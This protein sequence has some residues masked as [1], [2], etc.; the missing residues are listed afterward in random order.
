M[1]RVEKTARAQQGLY[2][3]HCIDPQSPTYNVSCNFHLTGQIDKPALERSIA[4][5]I[6]RHDAL[7]TAFRLDDEH[8]VQLI[9]TGTQS[10]D[11]VQSDD[12]DAAP[13]F[14]RFELLPTGLD[15]DQLQLLI[16][17]E[18]NKPFDLHQAPLFRSTLFS[19]SDAQ[20]HVLVMTVHHT[21]F[22]HQ[23]KAV[24][25]S[26]LGALYNHYSQRKSL[27]LEQHAVQFADYIHAREDKLQS[28]NTDRSLKFWKKKLNKIES[29]DLP[30]DNQR[31][32]L[33]S[34]DGVRIE[35]ELPAELIESIKDFARS[36]QV[37]FFIATL[38]VCKA[39]LALWTGKQDIP[40]GTHIAD[41]TYPGTEHTIGFLLN[42]LVLRTQIGPNASFTEVLKSVQKTSFNAFRYA[43]TPFETL[44]DELQPV[45]DYQKNAF[46]DVRFSHLQSE[47][48]PLQ[49]DGVEVEAID[50]VQCRARY[51]LTFSVRESGQRCFVQAEYRS[52][53][54]YNDT[55]DWLLDNYIEL[56]GKLIRSPETRLDQCT[57]I[58]NDLHDKLVHRYND[59]Q[60]NYPK[61]KTLVD[62][63]TAQCQQSPN[64]SALHCD[65]VTISYH[66]LLTHSGRLAHY[67]QSQ[68]VRPGSL[69]AISLERS[70]DMVV[71]ALAVL[72]AGATYLPID[73]H[74]PDDRIQHMINDSGCAHIISQ[75]WIEK[76]LPKS[77]ALIISLDAER[78]AINALPELPLA[79]TPAPD[80]LAYI[81]YTSGSTGLPKG[82]QVTHQN[83]V[84]FLCGM[85]AQPGIT[86]DDRLVAVTTLS[87]DIAVLEIWLPLI[88]GATSIIATS[89][90]A[91]DGQ[92]LQHLLHSQQASM[93]QATP[94]TWRL[95]IS[96][97][98][99]GSETFKA[100]CGGE[101]MPVDLAA[102]LYKRCGE[103]WNMYGPTETTVW[104]SVYQI[105]EP[106]QPVL[107]GRP[108][109]NTSM[110]ILD[111]QMRPCYPGV[112]GE[113]FIGGDGV[114]AGY[115]GRDE[116]T[117]EKFVQNPFFDD[118]RI[119]A[120]GDAA[121]YTSDGNIECL[122]RLDNQVK[123]RGHRI[124]L[125]EIESRLN[126]HEAV[127]QSMATTVKLA[128]DDIRIV[129]GVE[130]HANAPEVIDNAQWREWLRQ[131]LPDY[132]VPQVIIT[133]DELPLT[134]NGKLDRIAL[135][136]A[137]LSIG[138]PSENAA[139]AQ[140]RLEKSMAL[141]WSEL[142]GMEQ[143]PVNQTFFD[144]GGHSM[145]AM[146]ML[147][148]VRNEL[149]IDIDPVAMASRS[150]RELLQSHDDEASAI[151]LPANTQARASV[152]T[153][154]FCDNELYARLHRPVDALTARGAVLLCNPI[155]VEAGNILWAYQR[156]ATL[157]S[158][159]GYYVIRFDYY[160]CGNS[161]GEDEDGSA[162]RWKRDVAAAADELLEV[163]GQ[164]SLSLIGFRYGATL[165]ASLDKVRVDKLILWEPVQSSIEHVSLLDSR[166][167]STIRYLNGLHKAPVTAGKN[168]ITGFPFSQSMRESLIALEL[169]DGPA[170]AACNSVH[171]V[172]NDI[173]ER[174]QNLSSLIENTAKSYTTIIVN[175]DAPG[176]EE[177]N[178][179]GTWLPGKSLNMLVERITERQHE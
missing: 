166:Y 162:S 101:A 37:T 114:T 157:L 120:T 156:L 139:P 5:L 169:S 133:M 89:A 52:A 23:S 6:S 10:F 111:S 81:I 64:A 12:A 20:E 119:Y 104:S 91:N 34:S 103:V 46:F 172:T 72:R 170:I 115:L 151:S 9:H 65:G 66:E 93:M 129:A 48:N 99:Q 154:F 21:V 50:L 171:L 67:L 159:R 18:I 15:A 7:R 4:S 117:H 165:A 60:F 45:K 30:L 125:G 87:F 149:Q 73:H 102:E 55:I 13:A 168:E 143:V 161:M 112:A 176:M 27:R 47:E 174:V 178:D 155:F 152:E 107:I 142:L 69:V 14:L 33:P 61:R 164:T 29:L 124:E 2:I 74:Y 118:Q 31:P 122:G 97:N 3:L 126:A 58:D 54:F 138:M 59:S 92:Q 35:K 11:S 40:V 75:S 80:G 41:R 19:T 76:D 17:A 167:N 127:Q 150:L 179:L 36:Q 71:A 96:A 53:L 177:H 22:D 148:R 77:D 26:E 147:A 175:D 25:I 42:T 88:C 56:L 43:D 38:A 134:P 62:L 105:T 57:L 132:M 163:S 84:N 153:F 95:L 82:V 98:W 136:K 109:A 83:V 131:L 160:G 94:I 128:V 135:A 1:I 108:I 106:D 130:L 141:I 158:N 51:D 90:Q 146:R 137:D 16:N 32:D 24:L 113:L 44:V 68:G 63:I 121:R 8:L 116:L 123:V 145:L 78:D 144:L 28:V 110:Y 70:I 86:S 140:T 39:L 49:L 100:L 85:K 173:S 79:V